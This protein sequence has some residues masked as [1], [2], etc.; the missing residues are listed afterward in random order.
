LSGTHSSDTETASGLEDAG[1]WDEA[2]RWTDWVQPTL[3]DEPDLVSQLARGSAVQSTIGSGT[4]TIR[5]PSPPAD[6]ERAS[7]DDE[8]PSDIEIPA[9]ERTPGQVR[10]SATAF[11]DTLTEH[12]D[13]WPSV[14]RE[15]ASD[16]QSRST[17]DDTAAVEQLGDDT[18]GTIVHKLCELDVPEE[19]WPGIIRR[20]VD[21]P[22]AVSDESITAVTAHARAGLAGLR[23]LEQGHSIVS[24]HNEFTVSLELSEARVVG[25]IDHLSVMTDGYLV[26][27]YKTSDLERQSVSA[28]AEHYFPQLL[29][30]AGALLQ[31]DSDAEQVVVALVFTDTGTVKQRVLTRED[32]EKL[33]DW[34]TGVLSEVN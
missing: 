7:G 14:L 13:D 32:V 28:L 2:T 10:M 5:R 11:R 27:D 23:T 30:Y 22:D 24:R 26:V 29:A 4:Y 21:D 12:A 18:V 15:T 8:V 34:A 20:C 17:I 9:P 31:N 33:L 25:D 3:L 19:R 16:A 1:D 6:W